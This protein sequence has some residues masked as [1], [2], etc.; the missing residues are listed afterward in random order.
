VL[1]LK[2]WS[3]PLAQLEAGN[4]AHTPPDGD[5]RVRID[6]LQLHTAAL[7]EAVVE[8]EVIGEQRRQEGEQAAK[9]IADWSARSLRGEELPISGIVY[10]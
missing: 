9:K 10:F 3:S 1:C 6:S 2:V 8:A 4:I 7:E 5:E